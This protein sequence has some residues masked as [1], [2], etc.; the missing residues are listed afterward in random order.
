VTGPRTAATALIMIYDIFGFSPQILQGADLLAAS[1][2]PHHSHH[3]RV[4]MPDFLANN[5]ADPAWFPPDNPAKRAH[6][7]SYFGHSGPANAQKMLG[8]LLAVREA[9]A[10]DNAGDQ[11]Q[12][13]RFERFVVMGYCWGAKIA[14]LASM[15]GTEFHAAVQ[16]HPS[17]LDA[18]DAPKVTVPMC[19]LASRDED[20]A[21]VKAFD[22]ALRVR[23]FVDTY[24]DAPHVS[25]FSKFFSTLDVDDRLRRTWED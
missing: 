5:L 3:A 6:M 16:V 15:E 12:H 10:T 13:G 19:M 17:G 8:A 21:V 2:S 4:F 20:A 9:L 24:A 14:V 22:E 18:A 7:A 25:Y 11:Q 1:T 23:K